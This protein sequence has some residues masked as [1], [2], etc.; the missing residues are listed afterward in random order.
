MTSR[1][2]RT[3]QFGPTAVT[4]LVAYLLV[5]QGIAVGVA[6][7][8]RSAAGLFANTICVS[9]AAG[10]LESDPARPGRTSRHGDICCVLHCASFGAVGPASAFA[11]EAP[12]ALAFVEI[13]LAFDD[14]LGP[15][16]V[17]TPPLGSRAPPAIV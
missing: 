5:L 8:Q 10:P 2:D 16:T 12:P 17:A 7:G 11:G 9:K 4:L 15:A 13:K 3:W 6:S 1:T 14:R